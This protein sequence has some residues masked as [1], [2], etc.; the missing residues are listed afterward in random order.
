MREEK[1]IYIEVQ[2]PY[3]QSE[4]KVIEE[5]VVK[6]VALREEVVKEIKVEIPVP[7]I[8]EKEIIKIENVFV[9]R[10]I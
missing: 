8:V 10:I 2:T 5:E 3:I 9:D 6:V 7:I 4:P 1:P